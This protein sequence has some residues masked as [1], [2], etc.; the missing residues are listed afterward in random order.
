MVFRSAEGG[1]KPRRG[2]RS[3]EIRD[4]AHPS[5]KLSWSVIYELSFRLIM[6]SFKTGERAWP[7]Q[8]TA[9]A[10]SVSIPAGHA[11]H[12]VP[13]ASGRFA[14][15]LAKAVFYYPA[16]PPMSAIWGNSEDIWSL[17]VLPSLTRFGHRHCAHQ[18]GSISPLMIFTTCDASAN[19]VAAIA[20]VTLTRLSL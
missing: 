9:P 18:G 1:V 5:L 2:R 6:L 11:S 20:K 15:R 13:Q 14:V 17:G 12:F 16:P 19:S 4:H 7:G 8:R 3:L 10:A